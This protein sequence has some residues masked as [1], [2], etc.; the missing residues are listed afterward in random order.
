MLWRLV[1]RCGAKTTSGIA[2]AS[3]V[4]ALYTEIY[5][6]SPAYVYERVFVSRL[7]ALAVSGKD[8][9]SHELPH[10]TRKRGRHT[11][12]CLDV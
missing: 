12:A 8:P 2:R 10:L 6:S 3:C 11:N 9:V 1:L 5:G 4:Q 7:D